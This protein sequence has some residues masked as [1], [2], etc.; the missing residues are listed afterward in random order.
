MKSI[1]GKALSEIED[2]IEYYGCTFHF[3]NNP[4][5]LDKVKITNCLFDN[6]SFRDGGIAI[7]H[8]ANC[9]FTHC[10]FTDLVIDKQ[11]DSVWQN[12][13][14]HHI[15]L[16]NIT[17]PLSFLQDIQ[18]SWLSLS[19]CYLKKIPTFQVKGVETLS[20][21]R[22]RI[23]D[24]T[25]ISSYRNLKKLCLRNSQIKNFV[26]KDKC[27]VTFLDLAH[28]QLS[29]F[30]QMEYFPNLRELN[31]SDNRIENLSTVK[32][33]SCLEVLNL[34]KNKLR[35]LPAEIK[36]F[37]HL[38]ELNLYKNQIESF[39]ELTANSSLESLNLSRN[40][41]R[42]L[43]ME[44]QH[45]PQLKTLRL[46]CNY[47]LQ[48][49]AP[50]ISRLHDL[51][52]LELTDTKLAHLPG[53]MS[54]LENLRSLD[55]CGSCVENLATICQIT[56]LENLYLGNSQIR[57][58]EGISQLQQLKLIDLIFSHFSE[59]PKEIC[60]LKNLEYLYITSGHISEIPREICQLSKLKHLEISD[61]QLKSLPA[62]MH[63]MANLEYVD[64]EGNDVKSLEEDIRRLGCSVKTY[65]EPD[66][67]L[68]YLNDDTDV[69]SDVFFIVDDDSPQEILDVDDLEE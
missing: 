35:E 20:I 32:T 12:C 53:E 49:L 44:I 57:N 13:H 15:R 27:E 37:P 1:R 39:N 38:R 19:N 34:T 31:L 66:I 21:L 24:V 3:Q 28:N 54:K 48:K 18:V 42:E 33:N 5:W 14:A 8:A 6:C 58:I 26:T 16:E 46:N 10:S 40:K 47:P 45:F 2:N 56:N 25:N 55:L 17:D 41:L 29:T 64:L 67:P 50:Q 11:Q 43:P 4:L 60:A 65:T 63:E 52:Q 62:E 68:R 30:P 59:F 36:Y 9:R 51:E 7:S 61:H 23:D 69:D 22:C